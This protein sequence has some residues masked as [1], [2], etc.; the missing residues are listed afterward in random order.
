VERRQTP[1]RMKTETPPEIESLFERNP[2]LCGFSIVGREEVPDNFPRGGDGEE[3]FVVS[4]LGVLP[5]LGEDDFNEIH[6]EVIAA[7][8]GLIGEQPELIDSLRGRT[9]VRT[10]H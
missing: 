10:L 3:L 4:E 5:G 2:L 7:V 1:Q 8:A 6:E 9:F